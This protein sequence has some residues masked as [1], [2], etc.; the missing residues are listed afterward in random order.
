MHRSWR[1][2]PAISKSIACANPVGKQDQFIAAFG[3]I[4]CL[5][6]H[7]DHRVTVEPLR[8]SAK[9]MFDLEDNLLLFFTGFSR[10]A[11]GI[12]QDQHV[13]SQARDADMLR[14]LDYVKALGYRS[15]DALESGQSGRNS[16]S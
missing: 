15:K 13:R 9:T 2:R 11:G 1:N 8:V 10:A 12:L 5:T 6:F 16:A 7:K 3:G 4:T 14:N